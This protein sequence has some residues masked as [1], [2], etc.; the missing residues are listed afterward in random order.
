M[1]GYTSLHANDALSSAIIT[2]IYLVVKTQ[3]RTVI[4]GNAIEW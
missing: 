2:T 1:V 3:S 4:D